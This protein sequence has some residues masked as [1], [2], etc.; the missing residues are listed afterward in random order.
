MDFHKL[1][2]EEVDH[3]YTYFFR[4]CNSTR[5]CVKLYKENSKHYLLYAYNGMGLHRSHPSWTSLVVR[6]R[7]KSLTARL[8]TT[9]FDSCPPRHSFLDAVPP[10]C[11]CSYNDAMTK[12]NSAFISCGT[13]IEEWQENETV[14]DV[15][16]CDT[17]SDESEAAEDLINERCDALYTATDEVDYE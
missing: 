2:E 8:I 10:E 4:H 5:L 13:F 14:C 12:L 15:E 16:E 7:D 9:L 17:T 6:S 1:E 3:K 11:K